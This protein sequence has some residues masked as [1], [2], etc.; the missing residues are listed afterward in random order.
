MWQHIRLSRS[1]VLKMNNPVF[2]EPGAT[3]RWTTPLPSCPVRQYSPVSATA[4]LSLW[5]HIKLWRRAVPQITLCGWDV[6]QPADQQPLC[7]RYHEDRRPSSGDSFSLSNRHSTIGTRQTEYHEPL[8][9][10][11]ND[12]VRYSDCT[13]TDDGNAS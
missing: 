4:S 9:S 8:P 13:F 11:A 7:G 3:S 10:S 6:Q 1:S 5:Q 12:E 2:L